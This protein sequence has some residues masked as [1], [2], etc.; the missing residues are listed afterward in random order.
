MIKYSYSNHRRYTKRYYHS[1]SAICNSA[2]GIFYNH[3][4]EWARRKKMSEKEFVYI[5]QKSSLCFVYLYVCFCVSLCV[6]NCKLTKM[7]HDNVVWE[8]CTWIARIKT[9][10]SFQLNLQ[11]NNNFV[12]TVFVLKV[13]FELSEF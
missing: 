10:S 6:H 1:G 5:L 11:L 3:P 9:S 13:I 12:R 4:T 8:W 2:D 7:A